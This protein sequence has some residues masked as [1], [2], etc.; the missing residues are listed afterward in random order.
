MTI[1]KNLIPFAVCFC[2]A[3]LP[4]SAQD[5]SPM[6]DETSPQIEEGM[7]LMERGARLFL[8][9]LM[10]EVDP[11]MEDLKDFAENIQPNLQLLMDEMGPALQNLWTVPHRTNHLNGCPMV[12]SSSGASLMP[13]NCRL[14]AK[15]ISNLQVLHVRVYRTY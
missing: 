10:E 2:L 1:M 13:L 15:L 3:A 8:R 9:G 14:K 11:A 12:T 4:A 7:G 5:T 6:P